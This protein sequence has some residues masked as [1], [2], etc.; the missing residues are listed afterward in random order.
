MSLCVCLGGNIIV[1]RLLKMINYYFVA[2]FIIIFDYL[3]ANVVPFYY[4]VE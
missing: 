1:F 2:K 4:L 3:L